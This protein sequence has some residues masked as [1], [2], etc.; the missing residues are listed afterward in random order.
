[1]KKILLILAFVLICSYV[2]AESMSITFYA[3]E[4]R[5]GTTNP[6]KVNFEEC[7]TK[8]FIVIGEDLSLYAAVGEGSNM[9]TYSADPICITEC[10]LD[11]DGIK[12]SYEYN[13]D[14]ATID[15]SRTRKMFAVHKASGIFQV[16]RDNLIDFR[17][18]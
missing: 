12:I 13:G 11:D 17:K 8:V 16:Y 6:F 18:L 4:Y 7:Y 3:D 14:V 9:R 10:E 5:W 1:M 2:N 15:I